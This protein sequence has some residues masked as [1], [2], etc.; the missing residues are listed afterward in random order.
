MAIWFWPQNIKQTNKQKVHGVI[1]VSYAPTIYNGYCL[2]FTTNLHKQ[3]LGRTRA[4]WECPK[5]LVQDM[6][7]K[8]KRPD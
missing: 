2:C 5:F 3:R 8:V 1:T 6:Y 7:G 4:V